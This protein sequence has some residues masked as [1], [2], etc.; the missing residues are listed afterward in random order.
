MRFPNRKSGK[1]GGETAMKKD[2]DQPIGQAGDG[3]MR[4]RDLNPCMLCGEVGRLMGRRLREETEK[5]GMNGSYRPF[6]HILA[7]RD[8]LTQLE[9]SKLTHLTAPTVSVTLQK[10]EQ[11][12]LITRTPDPKDM[13]QVRVRLT[14]TGR[15]L[16]HV[17]FGIIEETEKNVLMGITPEEQE[18]LLKLL[19]KMRDNLLDERSGQTNHETD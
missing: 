15:E 5:A 2:K 3:P 12:G 17:A 4:K 10:M 19:G 1:G 8:G 7:E 13:R 18:L 16:H 14:D 9:L 6:I 11:D